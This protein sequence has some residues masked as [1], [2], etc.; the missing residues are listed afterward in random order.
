MRVDFATHPAPTRVLG[1]I[2]AGILILGAAA[3]ARAAT[4]TV[5]NN[6][7]YTVYP[8]IFP[9]TYQNGG[10]SQAPGS[11]VSFNVA[12]GWIGR[13]W[14]R[15]GCNG[16][17]PAQCTTGSCGGTGLQ[18]AGTTGQPNTSLFEANI[19]AAGTDWYDVSFVDAVDSPMGV[20]VSNGNCV[21]PSTCSS[22]VITNCP[23]DLR[24]GNAC[25]SACTRYNTDQFCCRGAFGN[26]NTCVVANWSASAR[27]YV[28]NIH[29]FCPD[30]YAYAYD[31][32]SG[33][34]QTCPT[35]ANYTVTFCPSGGSP[36]PPPPPPGPPPPPPGPPP[37][38]PP[39]GGISGVHTVSPANDLN[40]RVDVNG[41]NTA[42][43]TKIQVWDA[44][45]TGAQSWNFSTVNVVPAGYHNIAA[46]G[47]NCMDVAAGNPAA[48]TKVQLWDCNGS[49]AQSWKLVPVGG[50]LY[51]F[52]AGVG[53]NMCLDAPGGSVANGTQ[54]Q[55]W[56]CNG[57]SA[58]SFRIN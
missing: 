47:P 31:E 28:N 23:A 41:A 8:G 45:G 16:A 30:I 22:A 17:S 25:L 48:G 15:T 18:C 38:P 19:N 13:L 36:P 10:W 56:Q 34:L 11:T 27:A 2:L 51:N 32:G 53:S 29:N 55:I 43:G 14:G 24:S 5:K 7:S 9:P 4:F 1:S 12:S 40:K 3:S 50:G 33:A 54:F 42:N 26:P 39:S 57:S 49:A 52:V 46:L 6:C 58:Q 21:S 44:N 35:G 20:Q 37:P